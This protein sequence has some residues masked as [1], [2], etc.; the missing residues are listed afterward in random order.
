MN[1]NVYMLIAALCLLG[2]TYCAYIGNY[3]LATSIV[4]SACLAGMASSESSTKEEAWDDYELVEE[5]ANIMWSKEE[6]AHRYTKEISDWLH[7]ESF[8]QVSRFIDKFTNHAIE[9]FDGKEEGTFSWVL[10][11][12]Y[13]YDWEGICVL[14]YL[15]SDMSYII[16][17]QDNEKHMSN[18]IKQLVAPP[19]PDEEPF[20]LQIDAVKPYALKW[21]FAE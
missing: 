3:Q 12:F 14:I 6:L 5:T 18:L 2:G 7:D 11:R 16:T 1:K 15:R 8:V 4:F 13:P 20:K 21:E 10:I 17:I 9:P 19:I